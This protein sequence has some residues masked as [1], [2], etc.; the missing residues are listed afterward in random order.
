MR[1]P[2]K[3]KPKPPQHRLGPRGVGDLS[4][5]S[6]RQGEPLLCFGS[7]VVII[8]LDLPY[9]DDCARLF[10]PLARQPWAHWL[11]SAW[12]ACRAGRHDIITAWPRATLVTRGLETRIESMDGHF[13]LS[14]AC[15]LQLL[16]AQL[17]PQVDAAVAPFAGGALGYFAYDLARR[18]H[19]L[20]SLASNAEGLPE[21]AVG[22]YD[23]AL[24]VDHFDRTCRLWASDDTVGRAWAD[25]FL[26]SLRGAP[27]APDFALTGEIDSSL[28]PEAYRRAFA[29][30]RNY[31]REGDCYQVNLALRFAAPC[32]GHPWPLYLAL[33]AR[34]PAPFSAWLNFPFGQ[35][36]SSSPE[37]F[38]SVRGGLVETRPI[39]GTRPRS[40][41]PGE[42][43]RRKAELFSSAKDRAE[44]LMIVDL[45]RNDLGQVCVPGSVTVPSLFAVESF[46]TVHH[47]V[48]TVRGRLRPGKTALDQ[49]AAAF[50]GGS[51]TGAP[52]LRAMQ[53]IE[54]LEAERRGIYCGAIGYLGHD[55]GM[56]S[57]LAIRTLT[58]ADN[59]LR[60]WA[61]GGLV[62]DSDA[63][64]E[65]Q[66]CQDKA[67][68]LQ[69]VLAGFR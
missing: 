67:R 22:I 35:V 13:K 62:A 64:A 31:I 58:R 15:P 5:G 24:V 18:L 2:R 14:R 11:D 41:D 56:D 12:P 10:A 8:S 32:R 42:D 45:L 3:S 47:L 6:S 53:I 38:L 26:A 55:G 50:P 59:H 48:S 39:K 60:F 21:M 7:Y 43:A 40:E 69:E 65:Y 36:L 9:P 1:A 27:A 34:N 16:R 25:R 28:S 46:A 66:E 4:G 29:Q 37:R 57:N 17:G 52:K 51:I 49:L 19:R 63:A 54:E 20:P 68:A 30:V 23:G 44:N 61:G 33:R